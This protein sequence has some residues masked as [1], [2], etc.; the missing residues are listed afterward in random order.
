MSGFVQTYKHF[1]EIAKT[2]CFIGYIM[3]GQKES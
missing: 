3:R 1:S 2:A